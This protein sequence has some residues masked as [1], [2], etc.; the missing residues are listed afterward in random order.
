MKSF[1][2]NMK[3]RNRKGLLTSLA[4]VG[5]LA[6]SG[7]GG[8]DG[9]N[10]AA[11]AAG[12]A[13]PAGAAGPIGTLSTTDTMDTTI[14]GAS[15]ADDGVLTVNFTVEDDRGNS[16]IDLNRLKT[17]AGGLRFTLAQLQPADAVTGNSSYWTRQAYDKVYDEDKS[18]NIVLN[19]DGS[20]SYTFSTNS[21]DFIND[22]GITYQAEYTHRV[23]FQ[24]GQNNTDFS[25][26]NGSYDWQPS[27]G[28]TT[29][30]TT[31]NMVEEESCNNCHGKLEMHGAGKIDTAYCVTCHNP[32]LKDKEE[33]DFNDSGDFKVMV[34]K[35]HRGAN[36]PSVVAGGEYKVRASGDYSKT[37][38]PQ[39]IRNCTIC[40]DDTSE[41][42][43]D[44]VNWMSQP[45]AEAC[46]SCHDNV[47]FAAGTNHLGGAQAD[48]SLC[49]GCHGQS[50]F[51]SIRNNHIDV[52]AMKD[53]ARTAIVTEPKAVRV[54]LATGDIE[55]DVMISLEGEPVTA[56]IDIS[57]VDTEQGAKFGKYKY[58]TDNGML[59][60]NWDNGTGYQ[61]NHQ[62]VAFNDCAPDG[63]GLF[64]CS[65]P[66]L[67]AGITA[68]DVI[69]VTPVGTY[70]CMNEKD[71]AIVR[72]DSPLTPTMD[73]A[74]VPADPTIVFFKAGDGAITTDGYDKIGA[75][76][77]ACQ[78]CHADNTFHNAATDLNQCKTCHN[79]TR[80]GY[81]GI[82]DL[83]RH[84]HRYHMGLDKNALNDGNPEQQ[85]HFPNNIDNCNACHSDGQFDLPLQKNTR[86]SAASGADGSSTVYISPTAVVC[87]SCHLVDVPNLGV[88]DPSKTGYMDNSEIPAEQQAVIDH[89]IQNGAVFGS[90]DF[91]T[92]NKVESCAVCHA[93][94]SDYGVDKVHGLK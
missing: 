17:S 49:K 91:D 84:V 94:G 37:Q 31:R 93:I 60:I 82:G 89:M 90:S 12:P 43:P 35:I 47:D 78:S 10:G 67:L 75:D 86:A 80:T 33:T 41:A 51:T 4:L 18:D 87:S 23:A 42:T 3:Q 40:H 7:C 53:L 76:L 32:D 44:A 61:L 27:T 36:L 25:V 52:M 54:D 9:D 38:L 28:N 79:A 24:I 39:D 50:G 63:A 26:M 22:E 58:A 14:T 5:V 77:S 48:N 65:V 19:N 2:T 20:Y 57:D 13:G 30:I 85:D 70:V 1:M 83:K 73:V 34:H 66:G 72:C 29:G 62:E 88:I 16:F 74:Q 59:A 55:V 45:T 64:T 56:L 92:A 81:R 46:V 71:G 21:S 8:D 6:L 69:T 68:D 11:G 15:F